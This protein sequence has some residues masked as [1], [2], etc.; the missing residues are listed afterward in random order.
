MGSRP[1]TARHWHVQA[2]HDTTGHGGAA[3][4]CRVVPPCR[5]PGL[6]TTLRGLS[7]AVPIGTTARGGRAGP[8]PWT[9][10]VDLQQH[11]RAGTPPSPTRRRRASSPLPPWGRAPGRASAPRA[12]ARPRRCAEVAA[13]PWEHRVEDERKVVPGGRERRDSG[14]GWRKERGGGDGAL[15]RGKVI[16]CLG[17]FIRCI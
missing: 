15:D 9:D 11:L 8:S 16:L 4:P 10:A 7:H 14:I 3:V 5:H 17:L 1:G 6:G 12:T 2:W 13:P